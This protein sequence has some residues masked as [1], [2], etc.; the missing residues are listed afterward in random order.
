MLFA[1]N[2]VLIGE[3]REKLSGKLEMSKQALET[4]GFCISKSKM[5]YMEY[6]FSKR[7][8]NSNS[9]VRTGDDTIS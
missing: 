7:R 6:K 4:Y 3:S 9:E 1:D 8:T 5:E 2:I